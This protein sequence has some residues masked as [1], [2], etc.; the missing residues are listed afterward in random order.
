M[1]PVRRKKSV[2][3]KSSRCF[4]TDTD[5]NLSASS[6]LRQGQGEDSAMTQRRF[7]RHPGVHKLFLNTWGE[8][9]NC[10]LIRGGSRI[11][12]D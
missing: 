10:F 5:D 7:V 12:E 6:D 1:T 2:K 4:V 3:W 8:Y 11:I 9:I